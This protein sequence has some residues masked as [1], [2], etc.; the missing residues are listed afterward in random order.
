[1]NYLKIL[2]STLKSL[3]DNTDNHPLPKEVILQRVNLLNQLSDRNVRLV[4]DKLKEDRYIDVI[5]INDFDNYFI[6]FN[7]LLFLQNGGY[8]RQENIIKT[9][10]RFKKISNAF[11]LIASVFGSIY[12]I[13]Q[14]KESIYKDIHVQPITKNVTNNN[15]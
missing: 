7:G 3:K 15:K 5:L 13:I 2:D 8:E 6:T 9:N 11:L 10:L 1:M 4:F 14:I 12:T